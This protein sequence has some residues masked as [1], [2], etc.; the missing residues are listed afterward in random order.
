MIFRL[1]LGYAAVVFLA[2]SCSLSFTDP[3]LAQ[4]KREKINALVHTRLKN[5]EYT[6]QGI[7]MIKNLGLAFKQF[8]MAP[9]LIEGL[10]QIKQA[11]LQMNDTA[12]ADIAEEAIAQINN[13]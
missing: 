11:R 1:K 6:R 7:S 12:S 4:Q 3:V 10:K 8:G 13:Q 2:F 9:Q 5:A